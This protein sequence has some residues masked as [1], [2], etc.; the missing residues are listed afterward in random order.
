MELIHNYIYQTTAEPENSSQQEGFFQRHKRGLGI[1]ASLF[2]HISILAWIFYQG[3]FAPFTEMD[4][5]D[6]AYNEV[7]W[8]ELTKIAKPLKY[9]LQ[10]LPQP[11]PVVPLDQLE[12]LEQ[13]RAEEERKRKAR[14]E[15][16]RKQREEEKKKE[17]EKRDQEDSQETETTAENESDKTEDTATSEPQMPTQQP[18]FGLINARP[19]RDI[20]GKVYAVYKNGGLDIENTVFSI[21]L[22]FEVKPDGSLDN[23]HILKSSGSQQ[24][25]TAAINIG[26]AISESH[27]LMPL[28]ILSTT[29]ATLDLNHEQASIKIAGFA[30]N[31]VKAEELS[32]TFGQQL[33][34]L[35][36]L[37]SL[38]N[39]DAAALL[40]HLAVSH[41]GNQ[42]IADLTMSRAEASVMM[43]KNFGNAV[44][45]L[46]D[47]Q[48]ETIN[49]NLRNGL[50][51][52]STAF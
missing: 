31:A 13:A 16:R 47:K 21:T 34:G 26:Q 15:A 18:R 19:I 46:P 7:K 29:T 10:L 36:L 25:D 28:A 43:R 39:Q 33:A 30:P 12:K 27:A 1:L 35:R 24:I 44:V 42:L 22:G 40:S 14:A 41:K 45:P 3:V 5:V 50:P 23:I 48:P 49:E 8:I 4:F 32:I 17:A 6:E 2:T 38:R 52:Y 51:E 20:V 11:G 9:P 37:M